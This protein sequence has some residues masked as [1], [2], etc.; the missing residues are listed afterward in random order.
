VICTGLRSVREHTARTRWLGD[1]AFALGTLLGA[2]IGRTVAAMA[3]SAITLGALVVGTTFEGVQ[4]LLSIAPAVVSH[5]APSTNFGSLHV[6]SYRGYGI[7]GTWLVRAWVTGPHGFLLTNNADISLENSAYYPKGG[8]PD[9]A[10]W[11][12]VHHYVYSLAYQPAGRFW[13][14]QGVEIAILFALAGALIAGTIWRVRR[15]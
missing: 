11:L 9:P 13:I 6:A 10:K 8:K 12:S 14:F 1:V 4:R 3:A 5:I 2:V 15:V 7:P